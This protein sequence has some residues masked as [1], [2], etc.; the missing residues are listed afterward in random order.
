MNNPH[1]RGEEALQLWINSS[2]KRHS[3][4][5]TPPVFRVSRSMR[6]YL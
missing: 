6:P 5:L 4:L 1:S 2:R 3:R